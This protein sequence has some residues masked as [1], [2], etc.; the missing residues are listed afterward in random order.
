MS[1]AWNPAMLASRSG[2]KDRRTVRSTFDW[3][4][5]PNQTRNRGAT[6]IFG[7]SWMKTRTG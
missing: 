7:T 2:K 1:S 3:I 6:A 4:P 5:K